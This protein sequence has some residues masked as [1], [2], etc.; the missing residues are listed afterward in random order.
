[1]ISPPDRRLG[2]RS[3]IQS[4]VL[5]TR[6]CARSRSL[7][8]GLAISCSTSSSLRT[9]S[10][11]N[12]WSAHQN[13]ERATGGTAREFL[14]KL[15]ALRLAARKRRRLL[16]TDVTEPERSRVSSF[17]RTAGTAL[18]ISAPLHRHVEHVAIECAEF[19]SRVSRS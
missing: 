8:F 6:D 9:S 15:H 4:A 1:M 7:C 18:N 11:C 17:S 13:V 10:K 14:G 19:T 2:P 3:M 16:P 12:P 5:I